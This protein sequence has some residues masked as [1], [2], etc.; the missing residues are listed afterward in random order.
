MSKKSKQAE[1]EKMMRQGMGE[2]VKGG[3][4][5]GPAE[6]LSQNNSANKD[7]FAARRHT[8]SSLRNP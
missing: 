7:R 8:G 6:R 1:R 4:S 3:Q 2:P 5:M